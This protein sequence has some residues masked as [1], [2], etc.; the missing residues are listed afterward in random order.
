MILNKRITEAIKLLMCFDKINQ[1]YYLERINLSL[2]D[3]GFIYL[4]LG[5]T[6]VL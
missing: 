6:K 2:S 5:L 1:Y 3:K 4:Y